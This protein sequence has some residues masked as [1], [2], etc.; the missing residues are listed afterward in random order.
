MKNVFSLLVSTVPVNIVQAKTW[1]NEGKSKNVFL[2]K[3]L[4]SSF[5][6]MLFLH[7]NISAIL[8]MCH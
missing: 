2:F 3:L 4:V 1:V 5:R 7:T 6:V 8:L